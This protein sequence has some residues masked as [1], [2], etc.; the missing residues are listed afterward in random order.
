MKS[1]LKISMLLL[2]FSA[3]LCLTGCTINVRGRQRPLV[4]VQEISG[5]LDLTYDTQSD[6]RE[7]SGIKTESESTIMEERILLNAQGNVFDPKLM[8]YLA[9]VGLGLN[10]QEFDSASNSGTSSGSLNSYGLKANF[11]SLKPYP[12]SLE[13]SQSDNLLARSFQGPLHIKNTTEGFSLRLRVPE[14]PMTFSYNTNEIDQNSDVSLSEGSFNR[15][16][17]KFSYTLFHDFTDNSH[18]TFRSDIDSLSQ[19]SEQFISNIDTQRHRLIHDIVFG[20]NLQHRLDS[21]LALTKR[22]DMF[23]SNTLEWNENL[24]LTHS[25]NFRTYY[26]TFITET[27]VES[28]KSQTISATTGFIHQLYD[29]L[30]T[31]FNVFATNSKFGSNTNTDTRGGKL[32]FDYSR[33]NPFGKLLVELSFETSEQDSSGDTGTA[34]II[35]ES[36]VFTDPLTFFLNQRNV[37]TETIIIT[38]TDGT[39]IYAEGDD[40]TI[41]EVGDQVEIEPTTLGTTFP[42]ITD[43]QTLLIDYT[44]NIEGDRKDNYYRR[45]FKIQQDFS[46]GISAYFS[47]RLFE[48]Q[49]NSTLSPDTADE[50]SETAVFGV[51]Y[52]QKYLTLLAEHTN[53]DSTFQSSESDRVAAT[54][55]WPLTPRTS[56]IGTVSQSWIDSTGQNARQ[57]E[58]FKAESKIRTKLTRYLNASAKAEYR[59]EDSTDIGKTKGV[60]FGTFLDYNRASFNLRAEWN[61]YSLDRLNTSSESTGFY[62]KLTRLF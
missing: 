43:G 39:F 30:F 45:N 48:R 36:H 7:T 28:T 5:Q 56:L 20:K 40:Y 19:T 11:L 53:T 34:L 1:S 47:N 4:Q 8:T 13:A 49:I 2:G 58:I 33:N 35:D 3:V 18:M 14:W 12:F 21:S 24:L 61:M 55:Y 22:V 60:R 42:N 44:Y 31:N 51:K 50:T 52:K 23:T 37:N 6:T 16:S 38:S 29:N 17:E 59:D 46:N 9:F 10:Q 41:L 54:A 15:S 32:K 25:D 27:T 26:N 62:L 57:T